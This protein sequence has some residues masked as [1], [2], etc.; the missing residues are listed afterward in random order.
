M[1]FVK[2][3]ILGLLRFNHTTLTAHRKIFKN[4]TNSFLLSL[5]FNN[6]CYYCEEKNDVSSS[7]EQHGFL[8]PFLLYNRLD[9]LHQ[10]CLH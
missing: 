6:I 3:I 9:R 2:Y 10:E 4:N 7:N 1:C 5:Y 8:K